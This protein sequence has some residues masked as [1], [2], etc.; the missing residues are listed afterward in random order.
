[1]RTTKRQRCKQRSKNT[2]THHGIY[3]CRMK[4]FNITTNLHMY[5][6]DLNWL[7]VTFHE[8]NFNLVLQRQ[9]EYR[10]CSANQGRKNSASCVLKAPAV[11]CR[12][13]PAID[14]RP[15]YRSSV[16]DTRSTCRSTLGRYVGRVSV[17]SRWIESYFSQTLHRVSVDTSGDHSVD[18]S[19]AT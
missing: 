7:V 11:E 12:S 14:T 3:I 4:E 9:K 10:T 5:R 19:I 16:V 15:T 6:T 13:I 8:I 17:D 1:M 2:T 18:I